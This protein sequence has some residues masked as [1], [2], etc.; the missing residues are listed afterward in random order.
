MKPLAL[1]SAILTA[2]A[3]LLLLAMMGLTVVDVIGRYVFA[4]PVPGAFEATEV[5]LALAVFAG[6]P[7]VTARGEHVQ[8]RLLLAALPGRMQRLLERTWDVALTLLLAGA[9]KLL[10]AHAA[11]LSAYGDATMLL[12]IPLAPVAFALA[13]LSAA[14]AVV[15]AGRLVLTLRRGRR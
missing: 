5:M 10:Y 2:V 11:A 1:A 8:V 15:A 3:G 12:Q 14:A 13:T 4:K 7:I 9:A 6:L